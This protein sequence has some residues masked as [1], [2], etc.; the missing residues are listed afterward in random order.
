MKVFVT[1]GA[2]FIGSSLV[3]HLL[4]NDDIEILNLDKLTYAANLKNLADITGNPRY[5]FEH[6]DICDN[7]LLAK[8]FVDFMP[9]AVLHLAA[10]SHVDRSIDQPMDFLSTNILGTAK[11]LEAAVRYLDNL[12][13]NKADAF[14]FIHV[15]TDEVFGSLQA[16][17]TPF[18]PDTPYDPKSPYS[19]SKAAS[20]HLVRAWHQTYG[21]PVILT[22]CS[23]NYGP[24]QFPEKFIPLMI[25]RGLQGNNMPVY[26]RGD[27]IRDWLHV[28]D[29]CS[30]LEMVLRH[31][32][33]GATYLFGG[34]SERTNFQVVTLLGEI[35]DRLQPR[36]DGGSYTKQIKFVEDRPGHDFRY[37]IDVSTVQSELGWTPR[38]KLEDGLRQTIEWYLNNRDWWHNLLERGDVVERK[39]LTHVSSER[40]T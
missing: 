7:A 29:H 25:I 36:P 3:R 2:G 27:N 37:A 17:D 28:T 19:A 6:G 33:S 30:G 1:G 24:F 22:N 34:K 39:G 20:D 14:R 11:L 38:I 13:G 40:E 31:G 16:G 10:E 18:S 21:L 32:E 26:G 4:C 23:N 12:E 15:S 8:L 9:D 35:L 5:R